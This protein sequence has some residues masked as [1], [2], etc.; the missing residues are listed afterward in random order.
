M[1]TTRGSHRAGK[2]GGGRRKSGSAAAGRGAPAAASKAAAK[3]TAAPLHNPLAAFTI[4]KKRAGFTPSAEALAAYK[5]AVARKQVRQLA[6]SLAPDA[7]QA[8]AKA[9]AERKDVDAA[10]TAAHELLWYTIVRELAKTSAGKARINSTLTL[11]APA[12]AD[13]A[14]PPPRKAARDRA[15]EASET[16]TDDTE[17]ASEPDNDDDDDS[18]ATD[19]EA[20]VAEKVPFASAAFDIIAARDAKFDFRSFITKTLGRPLRASGK[21]RPPR[22][23]VVPILAAEMHKMN[24]SVD[25]IVAKALGKPAEEHRS[26][27]EKRRAERNDTSKNKSRRARSPSPGESSDDSSLHF[28]H[29]PPAGAAPQARDSAHTA[30]LKTLAL[31]ETSFD[32]MWRSADIQTRR[33]AVLESLTWLWRLLERDPDECPRWEATYPVSDGRARPGDAM[34]RWQYHPSFAR[35]GASDELHF[36]INDRVAAAYY[37]TGL[38]GTVIADALF[39]LGRKFGFSVD[40]RGP[41]QDLQFAALPPHSASG[42]AL[43]SVCDEVDRTIHLLLDTRYARA[44]PDVS[45]EISLD[46]P[47]RL[48]WRAIALRLVETARVLTTDPETRSRIF[49]AFAGVIVFAGVAIIPPVAEARTAL[50]MAALEAGRSLI[51]FDSPPPDAAARGSATSGAAP[52]GPPRNRAPGA[53]GTAAASAAAI[54]RSHPGSA[55]A[56]GS[57]PWSFHPFAIVNPDTVVATTGCW[58]HGPKSHH[59]SADCKS[60]QALLDN[61]PE[62]FRFPNDTS[63]PVEPVAGKSFNDLR[64]KAGASRLQPDAVITL[65]KQK[66]RAP[67]ATS[68]A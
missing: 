50:P 21:G 20:A 11:C 67:P 28:R 22:D 59:S 34:A 23:A 37:V 25:D 6:R 68:H 60:K 61:Y 39:S 52:A 27:G 49:A 42:V 32:R 18:D 44:Y 58:V 4:D 63:P 65:L 35:A 45:V 36:E 64:A 31:E 40:Q 56:A 17:E 24:Y 10:E 55:P 57:Q 2:R 66:R 30:A 12:D 54:R 1:A 38:R 29:F 14:A 26:T 43:L 33:P 9:M 51:T 16:D 7:H 47:A 8:K 41:R 13:A 46:H 5:R 3:R 62:L 15:G 19:E 48:V 53:P